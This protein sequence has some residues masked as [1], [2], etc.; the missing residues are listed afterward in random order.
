MRVGYMVFF[1]FISSA[2][3]LIKQIFLLSLAYSGYKKFHGFKNE[4]VYY[5]SDYS[6]CVQLL[7]CL[8]VTLGIFSYMCV[9]MG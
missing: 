3:S 2:S 5:Y 9:R 6:L 7:V 4:G 1:L 8:P